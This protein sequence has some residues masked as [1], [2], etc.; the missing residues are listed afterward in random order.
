MAHSGWP[1]RHGCRPCLNCEAGWIR[2]GG[3]PTVAGDPMVNPGKHELDDQAQVKAERRRLVDAQLVKLQALQRQHDGIEWP[4]DDLTRALMAKTRLY[5][6]GSFGW[7][8]RA[9]LLLAAAYPLRHDAVRL[10]VIEA[11]AVPSAAVRERLDETVDWLSERMPR[12]IL[13][14]ADAVR[15]VEAW[16]HSLENGRTP[17][18]RMLRVAR[19]LEMHELYTVHGWSQRRIAEAY[20]LSQGA[21]SKILQRTSEIVATAPAA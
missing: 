20:A 1:Y 4:D 16:K 8:D 5:R 3:D 6:T 21:V 2:V 18:H 13:L 11:Q 10:Y 14:P 7:L 9:L 12:P 15:E 19:D 17:K